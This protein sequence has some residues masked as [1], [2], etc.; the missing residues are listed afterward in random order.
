MPCRSSASK[1]RGYHDN[2]CFCPL[3]ARHHSSTKHARSLL[4]CELMSRSEAFWQYSPAYDIQ[5]YRLSPTVRGSWVI[6]HSHGNCCLSRFLAVDGLCVEYFRMPH[7]VYEPSA[8]EQDTHQ[9]GHTPT[10]TYTKRTSYVF[11]AENTVARGSR[12][13]EDI[14]SPGVFKLSLY[15]R[16]LQAFP[17]EIKRRGS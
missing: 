1:A 11:S 17:R 3:N 8:R 15:Q 2:T 4:N 12:L 5:K 7:L 9:P 14:I 13:F 16:L 10:W 6:L